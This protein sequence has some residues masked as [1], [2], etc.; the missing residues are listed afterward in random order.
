MF[1][2]TLIAFGAYALAGVMLMAWRRNHHGLSLAPVDSGADE[3]TF[4]LFI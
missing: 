2:K 3:S 1:A 4:P